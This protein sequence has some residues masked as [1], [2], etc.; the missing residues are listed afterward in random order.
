MRQRNSVEKSGSESIKV[1]KM[2]DGIPESQHRQRHL[3]L[4]RSFEDILEAC[5]PRNRGDGGAP[6]PLLSQLELFGL[7]SNES[8]A[9][10][11][12]YGHSSPSVSA[13]YN[14]STSMK[15]MQI[16]LSSSLDIP[17]HITDNGRD[18]MPKSRSHGSLPEEDSDEMQSQR[19][20]RSN[21]VISSDSISTSN[22]VGKLSTLEAMR[23]FMDHHDKNIRYK[24]PDESHDAE[25][26]HAAESMPL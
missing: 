17:L 18:K 8:L 24:A 7:V 5:R 9:S 6:P 20:G 16:Q 23:K 14:L 13:F 26:L 19:D 15:N 1:G 12:S 10:S 25:N 11:D 21:S 4:E 2:K 3:V 22:P